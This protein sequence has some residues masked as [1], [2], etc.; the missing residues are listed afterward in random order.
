MK[1][2]AQDNFARIYGSEDDSTGFSHLLEVY[3]SDPLK[4]KG[5]VVVLGHYASGSPF[6][7][8]WSILQKRIKFAIAA[9]VSQQELEG[10]D[11]VDDNTDE[12][13]DD[14]LE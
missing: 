9:G 1:Q 6:K 4:V 13:E 8:N 14:N 3:Y 2:V 12:G 11:E 10:F 5:K 7:A